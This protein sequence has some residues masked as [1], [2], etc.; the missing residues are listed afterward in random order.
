MN[1][2]ET[3]MFITTLD[4]PFDPFNQ[5]DEWNLFDIEHQYFTCSYIDRI[6]EANTKSKSS[7]SA[8]EKEFDAAMQTIVELN[9]LLYKL[10]YNKTNSVN[11]N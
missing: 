1:N 5:F 2:E 6:V 10:V 9:P 3:E 8:T 7:L 4:N 11:A